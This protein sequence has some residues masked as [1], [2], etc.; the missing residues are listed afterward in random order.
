[1]LEKYD[2]DDVRSMIGDMNYENCKILL[3]GKNILENEEIA[4]QLG[5]PISEVKK[6]K[7]MSVK[8]RLY[9]KPVNPRSACA[10][11]EWNATVAEMTKPSKNRFV[12]EKMGTIVKEQDK[13]QKNE[14]PK[15][16]KVGDE[17]K[18]IDLFYLLDQV[19]LKP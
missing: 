9:E 14:H 4:E 5:D 2:L 10:D 11:E 16:I 15:R 8:Y 6:E 13:K 7:W 3:V 12:P 17:R 1:M 19:H 18:K